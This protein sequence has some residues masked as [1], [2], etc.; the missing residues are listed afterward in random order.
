MTSPADRRRRMLVLPLFILIRNIH[1]P[2]AIAIVGY[3]GDRTLF[4][5]ILIVGCSGLPEYVC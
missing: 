5:A 1:L 2:H 3:A 4:N